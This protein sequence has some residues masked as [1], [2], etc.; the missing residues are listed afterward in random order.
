MIGAVQ[1]WQYSGRTVDFLEVGEIVLGSQIHPPVPMDPAVCLR[2]GK[3]DH[4]FLK[5]RTDLEYRAILFCKVCKEG[6]NIAL[7]HM[8]IEQQITQ[9]DSW[10]LLVQGRTPKQRAGD[11]VFDRIGYGTADRVHLAEELDALFRL[12]IEFEYEAK[13][14]ARIDEQIVMTSLGS[15]IVSVKIHSLIRV[16]M[17]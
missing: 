7:A 8:W 15:G 2:S 10:N 17:N 3:K 4:G 13:D 9:R 11:V 16:L 5:R 1:G 12:V 14:V 6:G